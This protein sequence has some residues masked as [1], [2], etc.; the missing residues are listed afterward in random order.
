MGGC[1]KSA[2][3]LFKRCLDLRSLLEF[4]GNIH[5]AD[6][7]GTTFAKSLEV[8]CQNVYVV[9]IN[10]KQQ[11]EDPLTLVVMRLHSRHLDSKDLFRL[12]RHLLDDILLQSS[13]HEC[14]ELLVEVLNLGF[15]IDIGEIKV[16]RQLDW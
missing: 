12:G 4:H 14:A 15:L 1:W 8:F 6:L 5:Q 2:I 13:Q 11:A 9:S 3:V 7:L 16:V 10:P